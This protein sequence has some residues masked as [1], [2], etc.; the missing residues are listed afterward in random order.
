MSTGRTATRAE[1]EAAGV[2]LSATSSRASLKLGTRPGTADA[3]GAMP[4]AP[5][6]RAAPGLAAAGRLG[7]GGGLAPNAS[8]PLLGMGASTSAGQ[9][10]SELAGLRRPRSA[11]VLPLA[12]S[13]LAS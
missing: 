1:A 5:A 9:P 13:V 8:G 12:A 11:P 4:A 10:S 7:G 6:H 2:V 3:V